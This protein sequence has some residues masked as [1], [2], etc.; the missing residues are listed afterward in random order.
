MA[1]ATAMVSN[2]MATML[3]HSPTVS[4]RSD[5]AGAAVGWSTISELVT[6]SVH[7]LKP[8]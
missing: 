2:A 3:M 4:R 5:T 1:V 7:H 6:A 8:S